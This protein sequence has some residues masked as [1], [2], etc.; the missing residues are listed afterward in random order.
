MSVFNP[1]C[2]YY[3]KCGLCNHPKRKG[4]LLKK[5][6]ILP[7]KKC[8]FQEKYPRPIFKPKPMPLKGY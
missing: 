2:K 1:N 3:D 6:C 7:G 8:L 4:W 5:L